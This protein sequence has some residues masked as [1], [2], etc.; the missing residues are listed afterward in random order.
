MSFV[1]TLSHLCLGSAHMTATRMAT[2]S[3]GNV[4]VFLVTVVITAV[5]VSL[6]AIELCMREE[7]VNKSWNICIEDMFLFKF[8]D[9]CR[10]GNSKIIVIPLKA[11]TIAVCCILEYSIL[12]ILLE[13]W[14]CTQDFHSPPQC[15][16]YLCNNGENWCSRCLSWRMQWSWDLYR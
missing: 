16:I 6:C 10:G 1:T 15:C 13:F 9:Y 2:V 8:L 3:M 14:R 4:P 12:I 5:N 7:P 11:K